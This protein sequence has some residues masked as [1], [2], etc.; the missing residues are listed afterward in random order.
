MSEKD[1]YFSAIEKEMRK[2][3]YALRE[4]KDHPRIPLLILIFKNANNKFLFDCV[5]T[6]LQD[7]GISEWAVDVAK[8]SAASLLAQQPYT[9][10]ELM[11]A[12]NDM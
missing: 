1:T 6:G 3:G 11:K 5:S 7:A 12:I 2:G 4:V 9:R 10:K 8:R